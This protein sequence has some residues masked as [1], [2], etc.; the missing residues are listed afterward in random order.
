MAVHWCSHNSFLVCKGGAMHCALLAAAA[1][2]GQNGNIRLHSRTPQLDTLERSTEAL[3]EHTTA[4]ANKYR[5]PGKVFKRLHPCLH[6]H[7]LQLQRRHTPSKA[8]HR[9]LAQMPNL[10]TLQSLI[11]SNALSIKYPVTVS[12]LPAPGPAQLQAQLHLCQY[13]SHH[14]CICSTR[15]NS[16]VL[17]QQWCCLL[18]LLLC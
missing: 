3:A 9:S 17:T 6:P 15:C 13:L 14:V 1:V 7:P 12:P 4:A 11:Q 18:R 2:A 10:H 8:A 16:Q 5:T